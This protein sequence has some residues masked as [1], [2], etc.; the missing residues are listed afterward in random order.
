MTPTVTST[1]PGR[2]ASDWLGLKTEEDNEE[3]EEQPNR[4]EETTG[5]SERLK[6]PSSPANGGGKPSRVNSKHTE[7]LRPVLDSPESSTTNAAKPE[8]KKDEEGEKEKEKEEDDWLAGA[9]GKKKALVERER[10]QTE[11]L[12][13]GEEIDLDSFLRYGW[14]EK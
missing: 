14:I 7:E 2:P 8:F 11:S 5:A 3:K 13:L 6:P 12:E 1:R 4:D 10:R 9:L